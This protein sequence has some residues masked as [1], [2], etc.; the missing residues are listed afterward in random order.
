MARKLVVLLEKF[1]KELQSVD[2]SNFNGSSMKLRV[3]QELKKQVLM[4]FGNEKFQDGWRV[5]KVC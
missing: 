1:S 3:F 2:I 4:V 5:E